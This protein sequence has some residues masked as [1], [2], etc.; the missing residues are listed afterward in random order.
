M[1][2]CVC[3]C[4]CVLVAQS[5]LTFCDPMDYIPPGS[6]FHGILQESWSGLAFPS[7]E[8][9]PNPGTELAS[10]VSLH[11]KLETGCLIDHDINRG[12]QTLESIAR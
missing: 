4:V 11:C 3:V 8:D 12:P 9:H 1:C 10:P 5:R 7:P 6:S 2:V